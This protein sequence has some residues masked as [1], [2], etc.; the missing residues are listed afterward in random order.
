MARI[1]RWTRAFV[2]DLEQAV[3]YIE[4]DSAVHARRFAESVVEIAE[5]L[6]RH[7]ETGHRVEGLS[8]AALMQRIVG[9]YRL[10]YEFDDAR[11]YLL[12]LIHAARD[13]STAWRSKDPP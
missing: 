3:G 6:E 4:H 7:A 8:D 13:L 9:N 1:L 2:E 5:T 10:I 11:V 12:R